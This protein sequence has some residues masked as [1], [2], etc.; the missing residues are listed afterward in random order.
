MFLETDKNQKLYSNKKHTYLDEINRL[1]EYKDAK[2]YKYTSKADKRSYMNIYAYYLIILLPSYLKKENFCDY[3]NKFAISLD[4]RYRR[5][6][7]VYK[8]SKKNNANYVEIMM[9]TRKSSTKQQIVELKYPDNYYQNSITK[10][11]CTADNPHA[12]L[13]HKKNTPVL[14]RN[15][16][17]KTIKTYVDLKESKIFKYKSFIKFVNSIK[18]IVSLVTCIFD[19]RRKLYSGI[20][21]HYKYISRIT[22]KKDYTVLRKRKIEIKNNMIKRINYRLEEI[23][24]ALYVGKL[25]D[26]LVTKKDFSKLIHKLEKYINSTTAKWDGINIYLG[27]KQ[28]F[29][30]YI[31]SH[32]DLE[33]H[34][35]KLIDTWYTDNIYI[36]FMQSLK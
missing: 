5:I 3:V 24:D 26:W 27:Y 29:I 8:F 34:L 16:E 9:F 15:G 23:Q 18:K 17:C 19:Q 7:Y 31:N 21:T 33:S 6:L 4:P 28:S 10:R 32:T 2:S 30:D 11:R 22:V 14:D 36:P 25:M 1:V 20:A 12:V 35:M 13:K